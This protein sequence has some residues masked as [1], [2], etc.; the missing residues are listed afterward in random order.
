MTLERKRSKKPSVNLLM[1]I[2]QIRRVAMRQNSKKLV[3]PMRCFLIKR[4]VPSMITSVPQEV[5]AEQA[6]I[7]PVSASISPVSEIW[8]DSIPETSEIF[9]RVFLEAEE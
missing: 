5:A 2:I 3:K 4:N 6:L 7:H 8:E 9:S 1:L